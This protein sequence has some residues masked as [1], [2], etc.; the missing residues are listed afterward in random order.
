[1]RLLTSLII[2]F[3]LILSGGLWLN[4]SLHDSSREL[5][6]QIGQVQADVKQGRWQSAAIHTGKLKKTWENS[7]QWWPVFLDHQEM[8][9]IEFSMAKVQ[10]YVASHNQS[11]SRGQ[12]EELRLMIEHIPR[13]EAINLENIL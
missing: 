3:A 1:M 5:T 7:A 10:E 9:N 6:G 8:D 12:L 4:H 2:I 13:K 11:L